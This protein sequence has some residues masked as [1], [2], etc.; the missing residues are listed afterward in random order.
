MPKVVVNGTNYHYLQAG[1]GP[2]I[3]MVH[4]FGGNLAVWHLKVVPELREDFNILAYDLPRH[5]YS[6]PVEDGDDR[7]K[8]ERLRSLTM[9]RSADDIK[10]LL[11]HLGIEKTHILG[12]CL[13]G[14]I[15]IHFAHR[16]PE[17]TDRVV[18]IDA[19]LPYLNPEYYKRKDWKGWDVWRDMLAEQ[20]GIKIP[21]EKRGDFLYLMR[22]LRR[23]PI[24]FGPTKG[25][26]R[27]KAF[28]TKVLVTAAR[29]KLRMK[30]RKNKPTPELA[31][32]L[33]E[34]VITLEHVAEIHSPT[35]LIYPVNSVFEGT[36][37]VL[38]EHLPDVTVARPPEGQYSHLVPLT[39]PE[40]IVE[41][42]RSF[43]TPRPA[44]APDVSQVELEE[45]RVT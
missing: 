14:D 40:I 30:K 16:Y 9:W 6:K 25:R 28:I 39:R 21:P 38:S 44:Q 1:E 32:L 10:G 19:M 33:A 8:A 37:D 5:G 12:H 35:L 13:G 18:L 3:V 15:A 26:L 23:A 22:Q 2:N 7:D 27:S 41:C 17:T 29:A 11:D 36:M 4:G 24:A 45:Q 20:A 43:L 34:R 31:S 42:V